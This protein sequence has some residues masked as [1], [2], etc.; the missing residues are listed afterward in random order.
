MLPGS[1]R[2]KRTHRSACSRLLSTTGVNTE[3]RSLQADREGATDV[4]AA[5]YQGSA[6]RASNDERLQDDAAAPAGLPPAMVAELSAASGTATP[7]AHGVWVLLKAR[8][9]GP[10]GG[11]ARAALSCL[12]AASRP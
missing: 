4:L 10:W 9:A 1:G 7:F 11:G 12:R 8:R 5:A 6:L 3:R 2:K